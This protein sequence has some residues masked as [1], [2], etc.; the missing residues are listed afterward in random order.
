MN[1]SG[2]RDDRILGLVS[3]G[4]ERFGTYAD[5]LLVGATGTMGEPVGVS[6]TDRGRGS[7]SGRPRG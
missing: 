1:T 5:F 7:H 6:C 2:K 3:H 4:G